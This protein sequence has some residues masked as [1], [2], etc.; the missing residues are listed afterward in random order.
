MEC[1]DTL[2]GMRRVPPPIG[3]GC[4]NS[5]VTEHGAPCCGIRPLLMPFLMVSVTRSTSAPEHPSRS[6]AARALSRSLAVAGASG[7]VAA[8]NGM[9]LSNT[10]LTRAEF[11]LKPVPWQAPQSSRVSR[12]VG[13]A[14]AAV[15][16]RCR[17]TFVPVPVQRG[18]C[19]VRASA[20]TRP[21]NT[22]GGT[23]G[24]TTTSGTMAPAGSEIGK[25]GAA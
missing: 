21:T 1:A 23:A 2:T 5:P 15:R 22:S 13:T 9:K 24:E 12:M 10:G 14:R 11:K 7:S 19:S 25:S 4:P 6:K 17:V 3:I 16:S 8:S 20:M 18:H